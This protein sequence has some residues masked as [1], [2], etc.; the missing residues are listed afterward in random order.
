MPNRLIDEQSPYLLQHAHNPVDWYPWGSEAFEKAKKEN[1]PVLVSIGYAACHWCHVMER[2]SFENETVAKYMNE[3]FVNI[4]VDREEYPDVDHMYMDAVQ[5][6]VGNGGWPLNVFVTPDRVPFYG[7]TY[8]PPRSMYG[9]LSWPEVLER[10]NTIWHEQQEEVSA[11]TEQ[12]VQFL[13]NASSISATAPEN[14]LSWDSVDKLIKELLRVGDKEKGGFSKAPKFLG[15][16]AISA[17]V[18][19]YYYK[20]N[21]EALKHAML[22]LDKMLDGGIYDQVGG[23]ISRYATDDNWLIPHFEKMLYDNA[24]LVSTLSDVFLVT[25]KERYKRAIIDIVSFVNGELKQKDGEAFYSALDA[26]SEGVEGKFYTWTWVDWQRVVGGDEV[27]EAYYGVEPDGN[28]EGVNILHVSTGVAEVAKQFGISEEDVMSRVRLVNE[29]LKAER[30]KRVRPQLDD[31]SLLSWN[32]LMNIAL[33]KASIAVDDKAYLQQAEGHMRWM[34]SAYDKGDGKLYHT[35][36]EGKPKINAKLDDHAYLIRA[37]IELASA[38][39]DG[40]WLIMANDFMELLQKYFAHDNNGFF[41]FSSSFDNEVPVRKVDIYDGAQPSANAIIADS[42]IKLGL[43]M[44]KSSWIEQGS[45]MIKKIAPTA[46]KYPYSFGQWAIGEQCLLAGYKTA[47]L[48]GSDDNFY[49]QLTALYTPSVV[50]LK[51]NNENIVKLPVAAYKSPNEKV[52]VYVCDEE[53]C[54]PLADN[55]EVAKE[56]LTQLK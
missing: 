10:M 24:L 40:Q 15:T 2:E 17:L 9:R 55:F 19:Q 31:K 4:K 30:A 3:H 5:A 50:K 32:A 6:I 7:G 33:S 53:A 47:V 35:W 27:V 22:S 8:F 41:Y 49:K 1:R 37:L 54:M 13:K 45:F 16:M 48:T 11:Q 12:M 20:G 52:E 36:K 26:D 34:L 56:L 46:E 44:E 23:G 14:E 51:V 29:K 38:T 39:G 28:W 43:C 18:N 42:L 25:G 21:E